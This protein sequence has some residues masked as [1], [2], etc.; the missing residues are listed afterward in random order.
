MSDLETLFGRTIFTYT[1]KQA[2]SDGVLV[3]L[4][5]R[6]PDVCKQCFKHPVACTAAV[7]VIVD[8]A[9]TNPKAHN[10]LDGVVFDLLWMACHG[11]VVGSTSNFQCIITGVGRQRTFSF[12]AVCGPGDDAEP[13][14]TIM[15]P[16]ED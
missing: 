1:R 6:C 10:D 16:D 13:V 3:D 4:S 7:Y 5:A 8:K 12:K 11:R 15:L 14:L 9:V 2:I